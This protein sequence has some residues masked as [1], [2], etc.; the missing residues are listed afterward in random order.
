MEEME[1]QKICEAFREKRKN[2]Y[3]GRLVS[4]TPDGK[5]AF[6]QLAQGVTAALHVSMFSLCRLYSFKDIDLPQQLTV[7]IAGI[8]ERGYINLSAKP[9][10]GDF[11]YSLERL[12]LTDGMITDGIVVHIMPEGAAAI[13]LAPNI[14]VLAT[15]CCKVCPGDRVRLRV[16]RIDRDMH[17]IKVQM[18]EKIEKTENGSTA[19]DYAAWNI[20]AE[21]V[22]EYV[23]LS[24]FEERIRLKRAKTEKV[25]AAPE[26]PEELDF[27]V[28]AVR[29]PFS[30]YVNERVV[31]EVRRPARVQD[32][33]FEARMGYLGERHIRVANA[34]EALK[35][36]S[37]WQLRRYLYLKDNLLLSEREIKGI[38]D[39]LVK[40]DVIA[41]LR[42]QSDEGNLLTRVLHPSLNFRAFSGRNPRNFGAKDFMETNAAHIKMRLAS[43]QLLL[44]L[45]HSYPNAA[46]VETHPFLRD[47]EADVRIRPRHS[48]RIDGRMC[49]LEAIRRDWAEPMFDK[50]RRYESYLKCH[51]KNTAVYMVLE[52]QEEIEQI[53]ARVAEMKLSFPVYLTDDIHCLPEP[54]LRE[55]PAAVDESPESEGFQFAKGLLQRIKNSIS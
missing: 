20:P 55:V 42:F 43:N 47:D 27:A 17:R 50:L 14:S 36:S 45:W 53:A 7:A 32:I 8:D 6:Y 21:E 48:M 10:F 9:A 1:Y 35:Y 31:R 4:I 3:S 34:V 25:S 24:E 12:Q 26:E 44:G 2:V 18:L 22:G 13:M 52:Q 15:A 23:E 46:E 30:T 41:V 16:R 54:V 33:Y 29:S 19:F 37:A 38:I 51:E 11:E 39:R 49:C 5:L 28:N 40:H